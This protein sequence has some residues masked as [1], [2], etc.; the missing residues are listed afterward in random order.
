MQDIKDFAK[1]Q[2]AVE[3]EELAHWD[4]NFWSERLRELRYDVNEVCPLSI[5][6]LH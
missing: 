4:I 5:Y 6:V 1:S 2:D 3:A